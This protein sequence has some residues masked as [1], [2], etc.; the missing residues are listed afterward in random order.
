MKVSGSRLLPRATW[1]IG[2]SSR[3][4]S[5]APLITWSACS[6]NADGSP[7]RVVHVIGRSTAVPGTSAVSGSV[8]SVPPNDSTTPS[9]GIGVRPWLGRTSVTRSG[10]PGQHEFGAGRRSVGVRMVRRRVEHQFPTLARSVDAIDGHAEVAGVGLEVQ[11][12]SSRHLIE[13]ELRRR[14]RRRFDRDHSPREPRVADELACHLQQSRRLAILDVEE[15]GIDGGDRPVPRGDAVDALG[16]HDLAVRQPARDRHACRI[17]AEQS[18]SRSVPASSTSVRSVELNRST[19]GAT[20]SGAP[21]H[22]P[23]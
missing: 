5:P 8:N 13:R 20:A 10:P 9:R 23:L 3:F 18:R 16:I 1:S 17:E 21:S 6:R 19:P 7:L 15:P 2:L 12:H 4:S 14:L 22:E 11:G